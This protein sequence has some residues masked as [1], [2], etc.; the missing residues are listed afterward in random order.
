MANFR[1]MGLFGQ[2][3]KFGLGTGALCVGFFLRSD[4]KFTKR[5][6]E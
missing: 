4:A 6:F 1:Q 3:L 2:M 5:R